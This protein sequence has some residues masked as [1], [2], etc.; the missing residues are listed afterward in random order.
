MKIVIIGS[1]NVAYHLIKGLSKSAVDV[2]VHARN[3]TALELFKLEFENISILT[4]YDLRAV[5]ADVVLICVKDDAMNLVVSAY[6]LS[7][8]SLVAHTSGTQTFDASNK[9][10]NKGVFYPLQT[11]S[12]SNEVH[13]N[14][15]PILIEATTEQGIELLE[16]TAQHLYAPY[17]ET[18]TEQR[19]AIHLAAVLTSNFANHLIGKAAE[20]LHMQSV[21]YHILQPLLEETIRKAFANNPF[22]VQTGPAI[23][24][25]VSTI[26]GHRELLKKDVLLQ[27][28]YA[29]ITESIQKTIT[30]DTHK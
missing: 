29:D 15:T 1:G 10:P 22:D 26:Q 16:Q 27:K 14:K 24:A 30:L 13:W 6:T 17:F 21:D 11:F 28:I 8:T 20:L 2:F 3:H 4:D 23:R 12:K 9:H 5:Q 25:D 19:K 7:E 18:N